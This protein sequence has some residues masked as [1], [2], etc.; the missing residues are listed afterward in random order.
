MQTL[1]GNIL[2]KVEVLGA[3]RF[4]SSE[5]ICV[6]V[7]GAILDNVRPLTLRILVNY[8]SVL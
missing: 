5:T 8:G 2:C 1:K 4:K 7:S 6:K 3:C